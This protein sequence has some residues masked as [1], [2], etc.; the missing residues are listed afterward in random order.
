MAV[1]IRPRARIFLA[2]LLAAITVGGYLIY[3][4]GHVQ[5]SAA[6]QAAV[7]QQVNLPAATPSAPESAGSAP[8][9]A[10]TLPGST[11]VA[12]G[13]P[14]RELVFAWNSQFGEM[15]ANGGATTTQGSIM[16]AQGIK[17]TLARQDDTS[18]M[19]RELVACATELARGATDCTSGVHFVAIMG[20]GTPAF[21]R[22]LNEQLTRLGS[23]F[24]ARI[25]AS[26]GFSRGEDKFMGPVEWRTNPASA[27]G[28]LVAGVPR[29]GDQN[30]ALDWAAKNGICVNTVANTWDANCINWLETADYLQPVEKYNQGQCENRPV[31]RN[32][33]RTGETHRTCVQAVVTW[34]PGDVNVVHGRGGLVSIWSTRENANQMPNAIIGLN[35]WMTTHRPAVVGLIR[36]I[37]LGGSAVLSRDMDALLAADRISQEVY[38]ESGVSTGYWLRYYQ[39]RNENDHAGNTI[40]LGGSKANNLADMLSV[41]GL[42]AGSPSIFEATYTGFGNVQRTLYP[43]EMPD[44]P[45][46]ASVVDT[47]YLQEAARTMN[48]AAQGEAERPTFTQ[49][50]DQT[51][52]EVA[53]AAWNIEFAFGSAELTT[54]A[55]TDTLPTLARQLVVSPN[56]YVEIDGYTD[57]VGSAD[58]NTALSLARANAVRTWL[59]SQ[60]A[61]AFP[62]ARIRTHG[63]GPANPVASNATDA[64]RAR[65]RRVEIALRS[66][67]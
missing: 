56:V 54:T 44:F 42:V 46:Y 7:P 1:T 9:V 3:A 21:M 37:A 2:T 31:V 65:N 59:M 12:A 4:K 24:T 23:N 53:R 62:E 10:V 16:A 32:G 34:T 48:T 60:S 33:V 58:A 61:N 50:G 6:M 28:G 19:Q 52:H 55:T 29:D 18:V 25:V 67:Q 57:N 38:R 36:G 22:G 35:A 30:I 26:A 51:A 66:A 41:F 8:A 15:F 17:L 39:G 40:A 11:V 20:D 63:Y 13:T 47:S 49:R 45:A 5:D 43:R 27:R 64:G 14:V